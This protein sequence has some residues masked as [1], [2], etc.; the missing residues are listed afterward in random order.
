LVDAA[1]KPTNISWGHHFVGPF[2]GMCMMISDDFN[3]ATLGRSIVGKKNVKK[4]STSTGWWFQ[5][6]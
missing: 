4:Q 3:N 5:P 6:P 2:D 1:Y